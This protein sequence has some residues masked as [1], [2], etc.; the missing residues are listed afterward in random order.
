MDES[1]EHPPIAPGDS[2]EEVLFRQADLER[3]EAADVQRD[4]SSREGHTLSGHD[5]ARHNVHNNV[6]HNVRG[7]DHQNLRVKKAIRRDTS[8][9]KSSTSDNYDYAYKRAF[10][11]SSEANDAINDEITTK[12]KAEKGRRLHRELECEQNYNYAYEHASHS[13]RTA[14]TTPEYIDTEAT[15]YPGSNSVTP[16]LN[17]SGQRKKNA[18]YYEIM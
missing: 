4:A 12:N 14:T 17:S 1:Q 3:N 15:F 5:N 13:H 16:C 8:E 6:L 11:L 2:Y 10:F 7:N 18:D 9:G